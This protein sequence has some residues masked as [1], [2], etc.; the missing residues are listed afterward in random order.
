MFNF[1]RTNK[2]FV[3]VFMVLIILP[4]A[5]WG[6]DSYNSSGDTADA[7][8][9]VDGEK[10]TRYQFDNAMRQQQN[11]LRQQ[12]GDQ[13][14][15][16]IFDTPEMKRAVI[17]NIIGQRLLVKGSLAAGL[18]VTDEQVASVIGAIDAFKSG[19]NF[20]KN[21]YSEM[22]S[23]QNLSPLMF[24]AS[25]RSDLLGQ[26]MQATYEQNGFVSGRV[27]D[28]IIHLN[29]QQRLVRA[30]LFPVSKYEGQVDVDNAALRA[31]YDQNPKEFEVPEQ[32]KVEYVR[33]SVEGILSEMDIS[34]DEVRQYYEGR[35]SDFGTPEERRAAHILINVSADATKAEQDAANSKAEDVLSQINLNPERFAELAKT[36]S[37]D[38][39]SADNGGD[40]GYFERG[41]MV[42]AFDESVFTLKEGEISEV[43]RSDFGYHI[44]KLV[45]IKS[46]KAIPFD[47]VREGIVDSLRQQKAGENFAELAEQFSNVVYEQSDTL[48][49]A[50]ELIGSD[51]AESGWIS[52][53]MMS[54]EPWTPLM[55]QAI[56]SD[57]VIKDKRNT[58]AIEISTND[59]VAA[60]VQEYQPASLKP[61]EDA[62]KIIRV[63]LERKQA[64][65][66]AMKHGKQVVQQLKSG[67]NPK[68]KWDV[69]R[70]I[71][72]SEHGSFD[73]GLTRK[74][75][76]TN[77]K[78]LPQYVG[79]NTSSGDYMVVRIDEVKEGDAISEEK[80]DSY[81][82]QLRTMTGDEMGK[83]YLS[84][85][86]EQ[87]DISLSISLE[88]APQ[89]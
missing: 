42:K 87:A 85:A 5:M 26:Q 21:L 57:D 27:V 30:V 32:V 6:M 40:L 9:E 72:R 69:L 86:N 71:T 39:G 83:A 25:V 38:P 13:L 64:A 79:S 10:I 89:P 33:F 54:V 81:I 48:M 31:Y 29:E 18:A 80:R 43:V 88:E 84:L 82:Q 7:V 78:E 3:Q 47:E 11:R 12:L 77:V 36:H 44:I 16:T 49:P 20:D 60:R 66:L 61:Y 68:L 62:S 74:I 56:F 63:K 76:Q 67:E 75:F 45:G 4:F 50:A 46:S 65:E 1:V 2:R 59:L 28:N 51:V 37:Q 55:I 23:R 73:L 35:I 70:S 22:L 19:G 58:S 8:G 34:K 53:N 17:E 24:E 52:K 15:E 14:D 41:M